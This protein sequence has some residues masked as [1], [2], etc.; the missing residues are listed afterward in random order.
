[1]ATVGAATSR[2][3][4]Y[5][6]ELSAPRGWFWRFATGRL[7]VDPYS[8]MSHSPNRSM[9]S[10]RCQTSH[11]YLF[12][13]HSYLLSEPVQRAFPHHRQK[14]PRRLARLFIFVLALPIFPASHPAS[15][16]GADELNFCVRDGNRWTLIAINTNYV[17][18]LCTVSFMSKPIS[19]S[20][21][22]VFSSW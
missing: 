14:K 2:P 20:N 11:S 4:P 7:L 12:P 13:I 10:P 3:K 21:R 22:F 5:V 15:I 6:I 18:R 1:M 19:G 9:M 17:G 16:V 8:D